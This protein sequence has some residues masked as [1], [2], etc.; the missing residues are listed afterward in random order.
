MSISSSSYFIC[1]DWD[2]LIRCEYALIWQIHSRFLLV[3]KRKVRSRLMFHYLILLAFPIGEV[4]SVY[5]ERQWQEH[6]DMKE[7]YGT[8]KYTAN[9][10]CEWFYRFLFA[11]SMASSGFY[12]N[13]SVSYS[14]MLRFRF[15]IS[16]VQV[17]ELTLYALLRPTP[18]N[19]IPVLGLS[20]Q[21]N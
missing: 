13:L 15:S 4:L 1:S 7:I 18:H 19:V 5:L 8:S 17:R 3:F 12:G 11:I 16:P 9:Q 6:I 14:V 10:S 2:R 21:E 20:P